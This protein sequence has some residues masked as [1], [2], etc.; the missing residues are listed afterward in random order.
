VTT[1]ARSLADVAADVAAGAATAA[2]LHEA[3]LAGT[4]YCERGERPG[5]RAL[6]TPGD[7]VVPVYSSPEQL[8]LARGTVD[9]F[10]MTGAD[11]LTELP[12]GYNLLLD[13][14]GSAP[15][16]LRTDAL[17][18]RVVIEVRATGGRS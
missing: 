8:A 1:A 11:L 6:G 18:R 4:V 13:M 3:L 15:L 12:D 9:W 7:G 16:R 2:E 14:G 10:A 5:F 17:D